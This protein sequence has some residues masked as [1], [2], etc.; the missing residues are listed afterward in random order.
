MQN[1][2][3]LNFKG[4]EIA[5]IGAGV[6]GISSARY[7]LSKGASV[8]LL[9]KKTKSEI[10]PETTG[11]LEGLGVKFFL[12]E[13]YLSDLED[14]DLIV[15]SPGVKP[16]L[17]QILRA[18]QNGVEVTSQTKLFFDLC[19]APIIGVTGTKGKGTT[20]LLV[21]EIIKSAG[22]KVFL[23]GNI[24]KAPLDFLGQIT[25]DSWVVLELS[26]FQLIDLTRSPH[27][28]VVLMTTVEHLDWHRNVSEYIKA[29][30]KIVKYQSEKDFIVIN[31]DFPSSKKIG[32]SSLAKKYY[33]STKTPVQRGAY[34]DKNFLVLVT[35]GWTT[36][37][38]TAQVQLPGE[39]NLQNILAATAV[40][41]ILE[42]P[43][44]TIAKTV[45]SFKGLPHRLE[46]VAEIGGARYY[47]DSAS[48]TPETAIAAL[49]AFKDPKIIILGGSS[50]QA[51][52]SHLGEEIAK[53]N[54]R[55]VILMGDE[56][57]RIKQAIKT[58]GKFPG[59]IVEGLNTMKEIIQKAKTFSKSG[60]IVLLS[61]A[62]AS[63]GMFK[64]YVDRGDQFKEAVKSLAKV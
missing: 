18:K 14:F 35:N 54:V 21:Y 15:R 9:D 20:S 49:K 6:E 62:C 47:S 45:L 10:G 59:E 11:S 29:K 36:I 23:G 7:L 40:A 12:G 50:K 56:A 33:F 53:N 51:D 31:G 19:P 17:P 1:P 38:N 64:N 34:V 52:F 4:K 42:I 5:V 46:F 13:D 16:Y 58:K 41:G 25:S 28:A 57:G 30:E 8:C 43:P 48:T 2:R 3:K 39:H 37:V 26:S 60:D 44:D 55:V 22:K 24:G 63:F 32:G 61:P 27:I